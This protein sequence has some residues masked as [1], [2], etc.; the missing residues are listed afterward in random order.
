MTRIHDL[1]GRP[2]FGPVPVDD[3]QIFHAD[4]ERRAFAVTQLAQGVA[5]FNTDA[6]RH[7][8][9]REDPERYLEL[10]YFDKWIRNAERMLVEG[11]VVPPDA[12]NAAIDGRPA[13][14]TA[15]RTT[16]VTR[17]E[18]RG[19]QR[20]VDTPALYRVGDTVRVRTTAPVGPASGVAGGHTR[21]PD[22]V[23]GATGVVEIVN[24]AWVLPDS[25]AHGQGES[26]AWVYAVRFA[27]S[28]LWPEDD[29]TP[30]KPSHSVL[31]D[32]FELYLEN[33]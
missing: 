30:S 9:E 29:P 17:P 24:G 15:V 4:W 28:D 16:A 1:G 8:V 3:D 6:F 33:P 5:K 10:A 23:A 31:V 2:G 7:G 14:G 12:V 19:A 13:T 27:A 18:S 20:Q 32:L 22:Y 26:P 25:H 11:G 21:L